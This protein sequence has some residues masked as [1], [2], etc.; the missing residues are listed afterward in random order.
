MT[1]SSRNWVASTS[2]QLWAPL[3]SIHFLV[4]RDAGL[5]MLVYE[6]NH[7]ASRYYLH[8]LP[9]PGR[10]SQWSASREEEIPLNGIPTIMV[11]DDRGRNSF[12]A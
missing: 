11:S 1:G 5:K 6:D 4:A 8:L 12:K 7:T 9:L 3:T 2:N 10:K